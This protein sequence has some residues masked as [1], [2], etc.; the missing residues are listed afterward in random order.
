[1]IECLLKSIGQIQFVKEPQCLFR[2]QGFFNILGGNVPPILPPSSP[3]KATSL[4]PVKNPLNKAE[5][6]LD[7]RLA[8]VTDLVVRGLCCH[9]SE[10]STKGPA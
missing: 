7:R 9:P 6:A 5:M 3:S 1:M 4:T 2:N 8:N 10:S